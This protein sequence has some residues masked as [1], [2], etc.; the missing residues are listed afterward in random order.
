MAESQIILLAPDGECKCPR[1]QQNTTDKSPIQEQEE[2]KVKWFWD[3]LR[4]GWS[5]LL[6]PFKWG[7]CYLSR[8][9]YFLLY[10]CSFPCD[11]E[12]LLSECDS[13]RSSWRSYVGDRVP[14]NILF[15]RCLK[16]SFTTFLSD[17]RTLTGDRNPLITLYNFLGRCCQSLRHGW[18]SMTRRTR[19]GF[20]EPAASCGSSSKLSPNLVSLCLEPLA[21]CWHKFR[22]GCDSCLRGWN[23]LAVCYGA[24]S[25]FGDFLSRSW[26]WAA[27]SCSFLGNCC[28]SLFRLWR[29]LIQC[30]HFIAR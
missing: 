12:W 13:L 15:Y 10:S 6:K 4:S 22:S 14:P 26:P 27:R 18:H 29:I 9:W 17:W 1:P 25:W 7:W 24:V 23:I 30:C 8:A 19:S 5:Y 2:D 20:W 21:R 11:N 3:Y 28:G 16:R